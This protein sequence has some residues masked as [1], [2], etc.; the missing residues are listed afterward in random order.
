[1]EKIQN[2]NETGQRTVKKQKND[3]AYRNI[4]MPRNKNCCPSVLTGNFERRERQ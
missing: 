1:M 4:R 2:E 3:F